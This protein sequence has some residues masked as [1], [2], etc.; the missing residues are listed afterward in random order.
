M[1]RL[2]LVDHPDVTFSNKN[3]TTTSTSASTAGFHLA[4]ILYSG[5]H[6]T[7]YRNASGC[8]YGVHGDVGIVLNV[9]ITSLPEMIIVLVHEMVHAH[10]TYFGE[11]LHM[12]IALSLFQQ[13]CTV[14]HTYC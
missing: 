6:A 7:P 8:V 12:L 3:P 11:K 4:K 13:S 1:H 10:C 5:H 9:G 14:A 2:E